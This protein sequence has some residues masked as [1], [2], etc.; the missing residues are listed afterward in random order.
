MHRITCPKS[1][2]TNP[3]L[4][5][6]ILAWIKPKPTYIQ[7]PT[8]PEFN[9]NLPIFNYHLPK[10]PTIT[11]PSLIIICPNSTITCQNAKITCPYSIVNCLIFIVFNLMSIETCLNS[12]CQD[13]SQPDFSQLHWFL[14]KF[15]PCKSWQSPV[16]VRYIL[17]S[18]PEEK[19]RKIVQKNG[20]VAKSRVAKSR[21]AKSQLRKVVESL[22]QLV[23]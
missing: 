5:S 19:N 16:R 11:C 23:R 6:T 4:H 8:L 21:V 2:I 1:T 3:K 14:I 17:G 13:F 12:G 20:V 7:L 9:Q 10:V 18:Y 15:Q 22:H